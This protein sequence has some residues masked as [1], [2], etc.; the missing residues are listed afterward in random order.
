[1]LD[2]APQVSS[3]ATARETF[4]QAYRWMLLAR[5]LEEKL[6]NLY[7]GGK[8]NGGV[9]LGKGQEALSA[10]LGMAL[11]KGD[12]FA[13]LIRD[14]AGRLAFGEDILE[15]VR[16]YLGSRLGPM[17]GREG[18]V[19]R[20]RPQDGYYAMISHVGA[21][22]S[23]VCGALMA[24]RFKGETG[25]VG[26]TCIGDGG[27]STGAFHEALNLAAIEKLPLVLVIAN[28]QFAYSTPNAKQFACKDLVDRAIGYGVEGHSLDATDLDA[29]LGVI[30]N[31]V[32]RARS[33]HGPQLVVANLLRLAG[34]GE[35]DDA[36]YISEA[37]KASSA[38][39][40]CLQVAECA[41][42]E[43]GWLSP[44]ELETLREE[45][46]RQIEEAVAT[47][48]REPAPDPDEE[49]WCALSTQHLDDTFTAR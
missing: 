4:A 21:M 28:N 32:E 10:S 41:L 1:M 16:T 27:T 26:A 9:F 46:L 30:G 6:A 38:G 49:T 40:D 42:L 33:G 13:P 20:G 43:R 19:H 12:I 17:R 18:N 15:A 45:T 11:K 7:R 23:V 3:S 37:L 48:Q 29:C 35:H 22:I 34:H 31:A 47:V 24:R 25:A 36:G 44:A 5:L 8:I 39:R 14:Q 2:T